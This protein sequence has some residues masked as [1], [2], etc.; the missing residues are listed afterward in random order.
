MCGRYVAA[1]DV[2]SI[3]EFFD[4]DLVGEN[5]APQSWNVAPT[6]PVNVLID[7]V[8]KGAS[9]SEPTRRLEAARWGLVPTWAKD[10]A[11]GSRMFNARIEEAADKPAFKKAVAKRRAAIPASGYYEWRTL[12]DGSKTPFYISPGDDG[13]LVFAGLY[14]WWRNPAAADDAPDK[15]L[16]STTILTQD[17][18]GPLSEI[19][20][21]MPVVLDVD[22]LDHWLDPAMEG[23]IDLLTD[24]ADEG[25]AISSDLDLRQV[26]GAVGNVRN[27]SPALLEPVA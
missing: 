21:R 17:S 11:V 8:P 10:V 3:V 1:K 13:F 27:D 16:L 14:E 9:A 23:D 6:V 18:S 19:H 15:W 20:D 26:G 24:I 22:A 4:V 5:L 25:A 12:A 2:K 7:T